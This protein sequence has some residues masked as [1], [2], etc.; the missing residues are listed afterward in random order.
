MQGGVFMIRSIHAGSR[1]TGGFSLNVFSDD[2]LED[3]HL[4]TLEVLQKT[5]V[6]VDDDEAREV[7]DGAGAVVDAQNKIVKIPP[8][9]VEDAIQSAP[10]RF[11]ACG[12]TPKNDVLLERNRVT[13]TNFGEGI[14]INDPYT[15]ENRET[16]KADVVNA[17]KLIDYLEHLDTY[18]RIMVSHDV[19]QETVS[20]HNAEA[21]LT[22]TSKHHWLGPVNGYC[23]RRIVEMLAAIV[24]SKEKLRERPLLT[25]VTC[26]GSPLTFPKEHCEIIMEGAR[27]GLAVNI[28]S[29]T[30]AGGSAPVTLAGT[31]VVLNAEVLGSLV[32]NQL[33]RKG[34][35][36]V[37]GSSTCP[38]DL[39]RTTATVGSPEC[40]M[41]TAGVA[42]LARKYALPCFAAGG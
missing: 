15:G 14:K 22:H 12:R 38:I 41:I 13:F 20:L 35:P 16:V 2:E 32:L 29:M 6:F 19:P 1:Q 18:E 8:H 28:V 24:G 31:L 21:S 39:W 7:F 33:T 36:V 10:S 5:G 9:V 3:I 26:P 11:I 30:M 40:G 34:S 37:Y 23:A 4:A 27:C 42:Q 17:A 25:F